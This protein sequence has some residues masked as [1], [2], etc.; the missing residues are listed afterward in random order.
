MTCLIKDPCEQPTLLTYL[1]TVTCRV[2][3]YQY[4]IYSLPIY[5]PLLF[6][7][8]TFTLPPLCTVLLFPALGQIHV[9]IH[10]TK[11]SLPHMSQIYEPNA[12]F[13]SWKG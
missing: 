11:Q 6:P 12:G 8:Q 10:M 5:H 13:L 4:L 2:L 7:L 1:L 9:D 3:E